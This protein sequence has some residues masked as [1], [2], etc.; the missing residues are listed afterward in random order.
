MIDKKLLNFYL[1]KEWKEKRKEILKRDNHECQRCKRYGKVTKASVVHHIKHLDKYFELGL[2]NN[3]LI[4]LCDS[5]HNAVHPE[6]AFKM[7]HDKKKY[8]HAEKWR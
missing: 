6:K 7:N 2:K 8:T 1:S 3:N 5:C 4:S